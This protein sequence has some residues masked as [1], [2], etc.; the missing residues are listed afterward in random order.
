MEEAGRREEAVREWR[1]LGRYLKVANMSSHSDLT[2]GG[3]SGEMRE[4]SP[5]PG[6]TAS[7]VPRYVVGL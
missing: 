1:E 3:G 6:R 2:S 4:K 7:P 5:P